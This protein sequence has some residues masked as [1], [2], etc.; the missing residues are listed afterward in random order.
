MIWP[1]RLC[2]E[3]FHHDRGRTSWSKEKLK[4][5]KFFAEGRKMFKT[6]GSDVI[7]EMV[8]SGSISISIKE[9]WEIANRWNSTPAFITYCM[10]M[11]FVERVF[12]CYYTVEGNTLQVDNIEA[13]EIIANR[14]ALVDAYLYVALKG[15]IEFAQS[16]G[17]KRLVVDSHI[18]YIIDHLIELK[19]SASSKG[20]MAGGRGSITLIKI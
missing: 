16:R 8:E 4:P 9:G 5:R 2:L 3:W 15:L 14:K 20:L 11:G 1:G 12:S 6:F 13:T 7:D 19:F 18:P 17:H 10:G